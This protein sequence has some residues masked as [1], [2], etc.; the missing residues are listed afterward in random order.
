MEM[1]T[2]SHKRVSQYNGYSYKKSQDLG[3]RWITNC[4]TFIRT[5]YGSFLAYSYDEI[6]MH[7]RKG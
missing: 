5:L 6:V 3:S 7:I 2:K 4:K 1:I